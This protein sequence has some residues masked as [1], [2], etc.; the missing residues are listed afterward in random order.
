MD[1]KNLENELPEMDMNT[2]P[3][4]SVLTEEL[5]DTKQSKKKRVKKNKTETSIDED[6][7]YYFSLLQE[8]MSND[9]E[10]EFPKRN[11]FSWYSLLLIILITLIVCFSLFLSIQY[12][13]T[14]VTT[15]YMTGTLNKNTKVLYKEGLRIHRFNVVV[16]N[17]N[18]KK[19]ALRVI[20][21]PGDKVEMTNDVL[22]INAAVFDEIYLKENYVDFKLENNQLSQTYTSDFDVSK[23][24]KGESQTVPKES[25]I[26]LGDNRQE[27]V[28]SRQV[29]FFKDEQIEGVILMKLWPFSE[30][31][32]IE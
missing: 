23:I 2:N 11:F 29:G 10:E 20:G 15:D 32:P 3:I 8:D 9:Q 26:L 31:G 21:M 28:D 25:Y 12:E 24:G 1:Q 5:P 30:F 22:T 6:I 19:E 4:W 14:T 7:N 17:Q 27:A 18:G 13:K 16:V